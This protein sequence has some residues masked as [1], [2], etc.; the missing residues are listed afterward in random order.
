M[1]KLL[2]ILWMN[3]LINDYWVKLIELDVKYIFLDMVE[4]SFKEFSRL[5]SF[6]FK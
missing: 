2:S 1:F 5:L 6:Y 4:L 3:I